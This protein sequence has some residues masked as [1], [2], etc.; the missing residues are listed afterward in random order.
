MS[1]H[2]GCVTTSDE[3]LMRLL[4]QLD[5]PE[6]LEW[7]RDFDGDEA[8]APFDR[9]RSRLE[10]AF[11]TG[12][13][14]QH[15]GQIQD[16]SEFGRIEVPEEATVCGTRIIVS[17]SKFSP[18]AMVAA[19]NP[20]AFLS[21]A[22]AQEEGELDPGDLGK[23]LRSLAAVGYVAVPEELLQTR[24]DGDGRLLWSGNDEPTWWDRFF[25]F[26]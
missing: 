22:E 12:C 24:Y 9:L 2:Y 19:D 11:G 1:C 15:G 16:S 10:A 25:G 6:W 23:A 4:R 3:D 17:V 20:G 14:A 18:L 26:Y 7:P 8:E 13:P 21:A 5:D